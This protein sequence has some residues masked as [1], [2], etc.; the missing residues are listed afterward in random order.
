MHI[1]MYIPASA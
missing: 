1:Y